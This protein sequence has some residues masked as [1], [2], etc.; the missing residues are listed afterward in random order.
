[1]ASSVNLR[2]SEAY[3]ASPHSSIGSGEPLN[4]TPASAITVFSPE[5]VRYSDPNYSASRVSNTAVNESLADPFVAPSAMRKPGA[6]LSATASEFQ[7]FGLPV[8]RPSSSRPGMPQSG[9]GQIEHAAKTVD[10]GFTSDAK[11]ARCLKITGI[12]GESVV[13]LADASLT[14]L[15][16][17]GWAPDGSLR[18]VFRNGNVYMRMSNLYDAQHIYNAVA[19]DNHNRL[20]VEYISVATWASEVIPGQK[21]PSKYEGQVYLEAHYPSQQITS[22]KK[23]EQHLRNLL[24]ESGGPLWSWQPIST[25]DS[26]VFQLLIHLA[27]AAKASKVV[28][29]LHKKPLSSQSN[30]T[31]TVK[32]HNPQGLEHAREIFKKPLAPAALPAE[33]SNENFYLNDAMR[34]LTTHDQGWGTTRRFTSSVTPPRLDYT[35]ARRAATTG[36]QRLP[37]ASGREFGPPPH[38]GLPNIGQTLYGT[39]PA[40]YPYS[41][42]RNS[43]YS[44]MSP[45]QQLLAPG[46]GYSQLSPTPSQFSSRRRQNAVKVPRNHSI[47]AATQYSQV[48][49]RMIEAGLDV[50]TTIMLRN[51]PNKLDQA[52]LKQIVD[53][54]SFG[55]YDFMY[56]RIDFSNNCNVGYAFINFV[57]AVDIIHFVIARAN[58]KWNYFNSEKVAEISYAA[59][60]G[61]E[62]LVEKFRN[63]SVMLEP[64][65]HRPKLFFTIADSLGRAGQEEP[66]PATDNLAKLKRSCENAEHQGLFA[67]SAGQKLRDEQRRRRSQYDRGTSLAEQ[68][69]YH[70]DALDRYGGGEGRGGS[71][72]SYRSCKAPLAVATP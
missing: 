27:D 25:K 68:E 5:V 70:Y 53:E 22:R 71:F 45:H 63:S 26:A 15:A 49:I 1:M 33:K 44:P 10:D 35:P 29:A 30:I 69:E 52:T 12:V 34:A 48:D 67:P 36:Q 17:S 28:D 59:I 9:E 38:L 64:P 47:Q 21:P 61:R 54:S 8:D 51:I 37:M 43:G 58:K 16:E 14:K 55:R 2:H 6:K 60:Q 39:P 50:K 62:S 11:V 3:S 46:L 56:L 19:S 40:A 31:M 23:F 13:D 72:S 32:L 65:H 66:F 42:M 57:H 41:D 4:A 20:V 7:P 24:V 18:K